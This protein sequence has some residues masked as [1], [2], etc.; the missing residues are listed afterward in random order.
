MSTISFVCG[1]LVTFIKSFTALDSGIFIFFGLL[2]VLGIRTGLLLTF[3]GIKS[4][5]GIKSGIV[6]GFVSIFLPLILNFISGLTCLRK[7]TICFV[8]ASIVLKDKIKS[9]I[10]ILILFF[11]IS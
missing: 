8:L 9:S 3:F 10:F 11:L 5:V 1:F 4:D 7:L 2:F 6:I